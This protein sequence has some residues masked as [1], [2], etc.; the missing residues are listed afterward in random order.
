[1]L[2]SNNNVQVNITIFSNVDRIASAEEE[3]VLLIFGAGHMKILNDLFGED[4]NYELVK[5]SDLK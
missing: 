4:A 3:R 1:M 2:N 5:L